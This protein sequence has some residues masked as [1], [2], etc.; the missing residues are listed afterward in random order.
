MVIVERATR[1]EGGNDD[2]S[3]HMDVDLTLAQYA[4]QVPTTVA[5]AI[6][7]AFHLAFRNEKLKDGTCL[8]DLSLEQRLVLK[9]LVDCGM[10]WRSTGGGRDSM[11]GEWVD[12]IRCVADLHHVGLPV[13][14]EGLRAFLQQR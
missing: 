1:T 13:T 12:T 9:M 6:K 2:G 5:E 3:R 14:P 4:H 11:T 8:Q 7:V 10:A